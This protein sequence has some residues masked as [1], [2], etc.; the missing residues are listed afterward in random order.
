MTFNQPTNP[1]NEL[2]VPGRFRSNSA[3]P[4]E[5]TLNPEEDATKI[6]VSD[7]SR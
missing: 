7:E 4:P 3:Y 6:H 5:G 2:T 1:R